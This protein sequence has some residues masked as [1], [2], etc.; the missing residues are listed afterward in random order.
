M[1]ENHA[2]ICALPNCKNSVPHG[3]KTRRK[4]EYCSNAHR[5]K[6]YRLRN[7]PAPKRNGLDVT[8]PNYKQML[9]VLGDLPLDQLQA[10]Q[11][12]IALL[13]QNRDKKN[14]EESF[15]YFQKGGGVVHLAVSKNV[16]ICGRE[17]DAMQGVPPSAKDRICSHC[18]KVRE[19]GT[20][21]KT[22]R[23]QFG[24]G[25]DSKL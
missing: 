23:K 12:H 17:T 22:W 16:T 2:A 14:V 7:Q 1:P 6:A 20:W 11:E 3:P 9:K 8:I 19:K 4:R 13:L 21:W 18:T 25:I 24:D 15:L 5:Q 10:L